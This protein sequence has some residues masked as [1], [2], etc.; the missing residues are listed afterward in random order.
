MVLVN[1]DIREHFDYD[2][3]V[4]DDGSTDNTAKIALDM[5]CITLSH[6]INLGGSS[7]NCFVGCKSNI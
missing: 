7:L 6:A 1:R 2:N 4:V 5:S 3:V